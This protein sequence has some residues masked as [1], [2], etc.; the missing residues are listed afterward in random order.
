M[1]NI[2]TRAG[3]VGSTAEELARKRE[4]GD[5]LKT[6]FAAQTDALNWLQ[7]NRRIV[8]S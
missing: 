3:L 2:F 5:R 1:S 6:R 8:S 7:Q 4:A